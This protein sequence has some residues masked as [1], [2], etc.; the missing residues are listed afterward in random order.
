MS[1]KLEEVIIGMYSRRMTSSDISEQVKQIYGVDVS[2]GT[3]S[4][5][6][7]R[8]IEHIKEWQ[9]GPLESVYYTVWMDGSIVLKIKHNGKYINK[10][11]YLVI[12]LRKCKLS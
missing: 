7:N 11:I 1:D 5:V 6:T 3:V 4:N 10:C 12:D 2:E 9:G 8:I